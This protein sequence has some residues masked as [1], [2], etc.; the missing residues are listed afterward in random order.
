[1]NGIKVKVMSD[2]HIEMNYFNYEDSGEDVIIL[3]GDITTRNRLHLLLKDIPS[4]KRIFFV[5]GNHEYFG[6]VF[7]NVKEY[8]LDLENEFK[9][10]TF[11]DNNGSSIGNIPVYGGTLFSDFKLHGEANKWIVEQKSANDVNDFRKI[12]KIGKDN[13]VREWTT[14]DHLEEFNKFVS[15]LDA[16][17]RETDDDKFRIVISHFMPSERCVED[18]FIGDLLSGYSA[19]NLD[20]MIGWN[21]LWIAGHGHVNKDFFLGDTRIVMNTRGY[22]VSE[23]NN[24][25]NGFNPNLVIEI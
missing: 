10:F 20:N 7:E 16:F 17:L 13:Q 21:G 6:Q 14:K 23:N 8:F 1:M 4:D 24:Y 22:T 11:L 25:T 15:G 18:K 12:I 5:A 19:S 2:L 3:A 9:N